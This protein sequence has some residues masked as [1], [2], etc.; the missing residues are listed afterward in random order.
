MGADDGD[1]CPNTSNADQLDSDG[2]GIGDVC[3]SA[4]QPDADGDG[5]A[6]ADDN[7]PAIPNANQLD[8]EW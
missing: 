2:D 3:D 1:N 5:V 4:S 7:C 6:D 8:S